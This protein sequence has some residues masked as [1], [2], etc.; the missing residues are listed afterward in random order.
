MK[1]IVNEVENKLK[2]GKRGK[3]IFVSDFADL[4][5][6]KAVNKA[7]ERLTTSGKLIRLAHGIY[8]HPKIDTRLGLGVLYPTVET[9]AREIA[10]R[11]KARIVPTGAYALNVLGLSTQI[12]MNVVFL[13]DGAPRKINIGNGKGIVFKRTVPKNLAY[14]NEMVMLI[15]SALKEIGEKNVT[16]AQLNRIE[17]LLSKE[18]K[19]DILSD[20]ALAPVWIQKQ[21]KSVL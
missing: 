14:K 10:K 4:G 21:I 6:A 17:D 15:V 13:T 20:I 12:P 3:I 9:V 7:L 8:L 16:Q 19:E 1:S 2:H 11:D 5:Q 18:K